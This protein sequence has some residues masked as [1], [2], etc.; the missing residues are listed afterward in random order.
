ML[1]VDVKTLFGERVRA[2]RRQRG[3]SQEHF[4][5]MLDLDRSYVGGV[6]RGERN[7]SLS[8]IAVFAKGL[9]LTLS[10]LFAFDSPASKPQ[11]PR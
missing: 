2:L 4:A 3:W 1:N 7:V 5:Q 6:E 8:N 9:G 11:K 10:E